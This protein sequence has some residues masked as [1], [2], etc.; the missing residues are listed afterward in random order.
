MKKIDLES[1]LKNKIPYLAAHPD[2]FIAKAIY[3]L[4]G[5]V[6]AL[7]RINNFLAAHQDL[8]GAGF[9]D[10]LFE[11]LDFSYSVS[12]KD[13]D[14]IPSEGK[15][16]VVA[17]HPLGG[18]EGVVLLKLLLEIRPDVNIVV[19]AVLLQVENLKG[20][21]L[22]YNLFENGIQKEKILAID[23]ALKDECAVIFFPAGEV[24]RLTLNGVE[25]GEWERGALHFAEKAKA[26]IL[27]IFVHGRNSFL[28]YATSLIL[29]KFSSFLLPREMFRQ[30]GKT[31]ELSVGG[32]I[33]SRILFAG[34]LKG[35]TL[36]KTLKKHVYKIGQGKKGIF[37]TERN[38]IHPVDPKKIKKQLLNAKI[39]ID[40][41]GK[42]KVYL[43]QG[44]KIFPDVIKEIARLREITFRKVG[45]GSGLKL[46]TDLY[47]TYYDHLVLWDEEALEIIGAYR[48]GLGDDILQ[49]FG[50]RGFY[51]STL[52][53]FSQQFN[54][55]LPYS[56]E[57]GRS[58]I[59]A[60]YWNSTALDTL[61]MGIGKF[62]ADHPKIQFLF[63]PVSLS[64]AI[65]Q[66][67]KELIV[68]FYRKWY[69]GS[70]NLVTAKSRFRIS[71]QREKTLS[72]LFSSN[73]YREEIKLIKQNL[74]FYGVS[75]PALYK[76]YTELCE[77]GGSQF[78]D[79][80]VDS[81]F[82][83]CIDGFMLL[84]ID[85]IKYAKKG[86]YILNSLLPQDD[87]VHAF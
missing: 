64:N 55:H 75:I 2:G 21:F 12:K 82:Q 16:V 81:S 9:L 43:L 59:Q 37:L 26:P 79:F 20:F 42:K 45:E 78:L 85:L 76:Q 38:V 24:S 62:L 61:W 27:P 39:L 40:V 5:R 6:L 34:L 84:D 58:F 22:P 56:I 63:G 46:D 69:G 1:V 57:L 17:N 29:K 41:N 60:K 54:Y 14:K 30:K 67:A 28:F 18:L 53:N 50:P 52:F 73:D 66:D 19:N 11:E 83:N 70:N 80:G 7:K 65:P 25:D 8:N 48:L 4:V 31:I 44:D 13:R 32:L 68:F 23:K 71:E 74:R 3:A 35:K 51:S 47:D 86:K 10:K 87:P 15:V 36:V 77:P 72:E 49:K 33:P